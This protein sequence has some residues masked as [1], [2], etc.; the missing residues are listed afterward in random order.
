[1]TA[2]WAINPFDLEAR[3]TASA[4]AELGFWA[5]ATRTKIQPVHVLFVPS[6]DLA[7]DER[8][9]WV[10][11]YVP[12]VEAEMARYLHAVD[13]P[14][15]KPPRVL[16][17]QGG[18]TRQAVQLLDQF[19]QDSHASWIIVSSKGQSGIRRLAL[20][21]FAECLLTQAT[22]PVWVFGS[23]C[24][25]PLDATHILFATDFS[26]ESKVAYKRVLEQAERLGASILIFHAISIPPGLTVG[27]GVMGVAGPSPENYLEAEIEWAHSQGFDLAAL[28]RKRGVAVQVI[29]KQ[30]GSSVANAILFE[31][32][33]AGAGI[34][35]LASHS[36][37]LAA[38]VL[39]SNARQLVRQAECP[40]WV[41][42]PKFETQV[43][44]TTR[45]HAAVAR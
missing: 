22:L 6:A 15:L 26:N 32:K 38:T 31:A 18:G 24:D 4:L 44:E 14:S 45:R 27:N 1:M 8:G 21:S 25:G 43:A 34:I 29:V 36:G 7:Q 39:G 28:A 30:I 12:A 23:Q 2:I 9:A 3:P 10:R 33:A 40:V 42:G 5:E 16:V 20:G 13:L 17:Q 11:R 37:T 35:A 19:T 41:F